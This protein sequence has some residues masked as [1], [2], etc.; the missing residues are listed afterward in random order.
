MPKALSILKKT[1]FVLLN[2]ENKAFY[3]SHTLIIQK[4]YY[5]TVNKI[6][7]WSK[8]ILIMYI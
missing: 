3:V 4:F 1:T 7:N 8:A 2:I 5:Y 6:L